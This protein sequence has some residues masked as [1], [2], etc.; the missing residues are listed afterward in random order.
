MNN[1]TMNRLKSRSTMWRVDSRWNRGWTFSGWRKSLTS[2]SWRANRQ[3]LSR[4][5][6]DWNRERW[7]IFPECHA[8]CTR[9]AKFMWLER[10]AKIQPEKSVASWLGRSKYGHYSLNFPPD[11]FFSEGAL[12]LSEAT[13][14]SVVPCNIKT[15]CVVEISWT[16]RCR[17]FALHSNQLSSTEVFSRFMLNSITWTLEIF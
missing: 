14:I 5:G 10:S 4:W 7:E 3:S 13:P 6:N 2:L 8:K 17:W 15:S 12:K 1:W 16:T 9:P 11:C